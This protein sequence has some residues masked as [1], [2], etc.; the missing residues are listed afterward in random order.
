MYTQYQNLWTSF[1]ANDNIS[2]ECDD[3]ALVR[4]FRSI[5]GRYSPDTLW[6]EYSC[7]NS[8]FIDKCRVNLKGLPRLNKYLN[9]AKKSKKFSAKEID[10]ILVTKQDKN[11]TKANLQG[12]AIALLY[13]GLLRAVEVQMIKMEDVKVEATDIRK[14]IEVTFKHKRKQRNE[15]FVCC[16][17]T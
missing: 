14:I 13:Y 11:D 17:P 2:N 8:R 7:L 4:F 16:I 12:V 6:V 1:V 10:T 9:V 5:Q 15:G 3:V